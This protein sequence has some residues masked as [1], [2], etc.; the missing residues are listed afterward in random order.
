MRANSFGLIVEGGYDVAVFETLI[1]RLTSSDIEIRHR[2]C[3]G[4]TNLMREFPAL[5]RTFEHSIDGNPVEM[6]LVIRDS[7]G[8]DPS[9]VESQMQAKIQNRSYPFAQGVHFVAIQQAMDAW[10]LS[11]ASALDAASQRR[12]GRRITRTADAPEDLVRPKEYLR[13]LLAVN[14]V[15]YTAELCRE[16]AQEADLDTLANTCPRFSLFRELVDC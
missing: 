3:G 11:D 14:R 15:T 1:R 10:L 16:I 8:K 12:G 2:N 9:E 7:D 5:L 4:R 13:N 6:A